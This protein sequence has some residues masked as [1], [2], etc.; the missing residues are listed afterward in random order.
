MQVLRDR[1]REFQTEGAAKG[2]MY[3]LTTR[4]YQM[5]RHKSTCNKSWSEERKVRDAV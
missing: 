3:L 1:D 2:K 5:K 4:S